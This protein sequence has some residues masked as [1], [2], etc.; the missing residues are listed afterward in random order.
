MSEKNLPIKLVLQKSTDIKKNEPGGSLKFFGEVTEEL[1]KELVE[2][3]NYISD[4]YEEVFAENEH[5]PAVGKIVVKQEAIA[6]SHKPNDLCRKCT[7]IGSE[8]LDEIYIKVTKKNIDET[9]ELIKN[10]PSKKFCANLTTVLDIQPVTAEDKISEELVQI[11]QQGKFD[12]IKSKIKIKIFDFDDAYDNSQIIEYIIQKLNKMGFSYKYDFITYGEDIKF[13]KVEVSSYEDVVKIAS[14]NGIK[15]VDFFQEYSLPLNEF[16]ETDLETFLKDE[17]TDS[18]ILIGI[19]DGGISDNNALL[20]PYIFAREEY[21]NEAYRNPNHATFIASTIQYGNKLNGIEENNPRRFKF[22][23]IVAIPNGDKNFGPTDTISEE[24]LME[25]IEDVMDKYSSI[26]KIWNISLGI[27]KFVC[28]GTMSDLGI[29]LDYIQDRYKVQIFVSSGNLNQ[30]P[31]RTWPPQGTMG[32]R[33]RIISPADS[34]RAI[35]VGSIALYDSEDSIVKCN[36]PSPFSRRGPGSNYIVKPEVVDFGGNINSEFSIMGLGMKGLD[37]DGKV[38]EGIGTSYSNPRVVQKFSSVYDEMIE[39][40]LLLAKAMTIHSARMTSRELLDQ[41]QNNIKY[42]GFG[43][44]S[45]NTQDILQCSEDEITLVFRQKISQGS[46]L[47]MFD[48]PYPNSLIRNGKCFGEIGMTLAYN[49]ILDQRYGSEYCRTNIDVSFGTYKFTPDGK[50]KFAGCVPLENSWDEKFEKSRVENGFKWSPI[51]SYYRKISRGI[52]VGD[53][54]KI[55]IDMN[56]RS[57]LVVLPQ[58]FVLIITI[59][60]SEGHDIYSE[61]V[62]GLR[63]LGYVTNN[64]ET[65]QQIRQRQ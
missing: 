43:M 9:V 52:Q 56:P 55:R 20:S 35:T 37:I 38:V 12:K 58:E 13:I 24:E 42:Y 4:F 53:G 23:D 16:T 49:P 18:E 25:I 28:Q 57:G 11:S 36:E 29:F 31:L 19:I 39:K 27:E 10:P 26:V 3:F 50:I 34:V 30:L 46:H 62:N 22:V 40:D 1:Q 45:V 41:D 5:V 64:L 47:E 2:K 15:S 6:K 44:P 7:I 61:V 59:K 33:D 21:V 14:I 8:D 63:A 32:E 48:F 54:W 17:Y 65:K 51:K 60:D